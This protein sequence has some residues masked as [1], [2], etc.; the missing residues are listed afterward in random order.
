MFVLLYL[1]TNIVNNLEDA[2]ILSTVT[3]ASRK[4]CQ[5]FNPCQAVVLHCFKFL[6]IGN[7]HAKTVRATAAKMMWETNMHMRR[8]AAFSSEGERLQNPHCFTTQSP[9]HLKQVD[10]SRW[11]IRPHVV[12]KTAWP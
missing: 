4:G 6:H 12:L 1:L 3:S 7:L 2:T 8:S 5:E 10:S 11:E 9:S